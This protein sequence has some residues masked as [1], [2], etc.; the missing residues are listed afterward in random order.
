M[1]KILRKFYEN[2]KAQFLKLEFLLAQ[3]R[4]F[5]VIVFKTLK[6][7]FKFKHIILITKV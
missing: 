3:N 2:H 4:Y 5:V 1:V 7:K 6:M